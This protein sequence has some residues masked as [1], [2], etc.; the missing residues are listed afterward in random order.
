MSV[1]EHGWLSSSKRQKNQLS[2]TPSIEHNIQT[3]NR[4]NVCTLIIIS[5][6]NKI[7]INRFNKTTLCV[8][9]LVPHIT[10]MYMLNYLIVFDFWVHWW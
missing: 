9:S 8:M 10:C 3:Q 7:K 4:E 1:K 2:Y 6:S 5:L